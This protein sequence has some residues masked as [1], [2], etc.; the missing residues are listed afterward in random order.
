[1]THTNLTSR[2]TRRLGERRALR[3]VIAASLVAIMACSVSIGAARAAMPVIRDVQRKVV[4]I[5]GA[6]GLR[7]MEAYQSG[8]LVSA[9]GHV[10]TALSYVLD[11]D[12]VAAVLDDGRKFSV[13]FVG[14]DPVLELAVLK[15][16][17]GDEQVSWFDL[18]EAAAAA[19]GEPVL[20]VS[21]L[22]GIAAGDEPASILQGV[23]TAIAPLEARRGAFQAN[24]RGDVYV[25]DAHAN[26]PG[27]A[28]GALVDWRGRLL[29]VLGKELKSRVTGAWLNYAL[30]VETWAGSVE[31]IIAGR[32]ATGSPGLALA[33]EEPLTLADLGVVLVP[34]L[35]A[36]TPAYLDAVRPGSPAASAG[37]RPDDLIVFVAG[38][39]TA[40]CSEV[41]ETL[42][43][44]DRR[45]ELRMA[46]LREGELVD[47]VLAAEIDEEPAGPPSSA[48]EVDEPA[49]DESDST[50]P[51]AGE[52]NREGA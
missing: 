31:A 32:N 33:P 22:Y 9:E 2:T 43:R 28:G 44:I 46:V 51:A 8:I 23:V 17:L 37:L 11:T 6:G 21:N 34:N 1:M 41:I 4:K 15:L 13:E 29:G 36:R 25:V 18:K 16:N 39:P 5:Y 10:V 49:A 30:P 50:E 27:A 52:S 38:E 47:V 48:G 42:G 40:S 3:C 12:D 24:Y 26:N 35:L 45:D 7:Q 14:S 20:A 19:P